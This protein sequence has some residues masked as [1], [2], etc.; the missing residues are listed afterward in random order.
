MLLFALPRLPVVA[1]S[2]PLSA[3]LV[4]RPR[5]SEKA[6]SV[7]IPDPGPVLVSAAALAVRRERE[8]KLELEQGQEPQQEAVLTPSSET[9]PGLVRAPAAGT[10]PVGC[11]WLGS[12]ARGLARPPESAVTLVAAAAAASGAELAVIPESEHELEPERRVERSVLA[13]GFVQETETGQFA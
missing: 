5:P 1:P 4:Q 8:Q 13:A 6:A 9:G 12:Q 7:L 11:S 10:L 3:E 2:S